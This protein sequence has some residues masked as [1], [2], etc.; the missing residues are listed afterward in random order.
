MSAPHEGRIGNT[1][2]YYALSP[3]GDMRLEQGEDALVIRYPDLVAV[4]QAMASLAHV[5]LPRPEV[6]HSPLLDVERLVDNIGPVDLDRVDVSSHDIVAIAEHI[7]R[8]LQAAGGSDHP[9]GI[10]VHGVEVKCDLLL[11]RGE[12]KALA[13]GVYT[14]KHVKP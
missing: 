10:T 6:Q 9:S 5:T 4:V 14:V 11:Q 3:T 2:V 1:N 7:G 8:D 13:T 12:M